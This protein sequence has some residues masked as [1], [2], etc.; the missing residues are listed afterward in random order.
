MYLMLIAQVLLK[1]IW[2][3]SEL[4]NYFRKR[5]WNCCL[6][7]FVMFF[8][9]AWVDP[10]ER[11]GTS[12]SQ[13]RPFSALSKNSG[14]ASAV[15]TCLLRSLS[16]PYQKK[17]LQVMAYRSLSPKTPVTR[18]AKMCLLRS[19]P[20]SCQKKDWNDNDKALKRLM[21]CGT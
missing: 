15:K 17:D 10:A 13:S 8:T 12:A 14:E 21:F 1:N 5:A 4:T 7:L 16:V 9:E 6:I 2:Q 3:C 18:A 19:F 11:P 20:L